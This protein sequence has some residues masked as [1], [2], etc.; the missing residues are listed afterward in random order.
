M[1]DWLLWALWALPWQC[2]PNY[3]LRCSGCRSTQIHD[4]Q[5]L[6]QPGH[7]DCQHVLPFELACILRWQYVPGMSSLCIAGTALYVA[8]LAMA[9]A[10]VAA[11]AITY[12]A[13]RSAVKLAWMA[14]GWSSGANL[15]IT[16][17]QSLTTVMLA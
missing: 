8:L 16:T 1:Q 7:V 17:N 3:G 14:M 6:C 9:G 12:V 13:L 4:H 2:T 11:A 5:Q 15:P 10:V